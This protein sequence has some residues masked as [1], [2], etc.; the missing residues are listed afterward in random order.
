MQAKAVTER[1]LGATGTQP[2]TQQT[3]SLSCGMTS[4]EGK[5]GVVHESEQGGA[6][7]RFAL[8]HVH[9]SRPAPSGAHC[10]A[11]LGC[12][13]GPSCGHTG[14]RTPRPPCRWHSSKA[15]NGAV[16]KR[17]GRLRERKREAVKSIGEHAQA[18][19]P[20]QPHVC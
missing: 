1:P 4:L 16:T 2:I 9:G 19:A 10:P 18:L 13:S 17:V 14:I 3:R 7:V 12:I 5:P 15:K 20:I 8:S 11:R 6:C